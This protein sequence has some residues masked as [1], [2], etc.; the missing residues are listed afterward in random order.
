MLDERSNVLF[1]EESDWPPGVATASARNVR[2]FAP[3]DFHFLISKVLNIAL[4][5]EC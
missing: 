4:R 1:E 3:A 2:L 5:L